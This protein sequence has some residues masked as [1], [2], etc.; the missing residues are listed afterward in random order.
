MFAQRRERLDL[1]RTIVDPRVIM[2]TASTRPRPLTRRDGPDSLRNGSKS[3]K[4]PPTSIIPGDESR[5]RRYTD[6]AP[7]TVGRNH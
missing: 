4:K 2:T 7:R 3:K 5:R 6:A 1:R